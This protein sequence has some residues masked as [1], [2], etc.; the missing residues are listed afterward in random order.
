MRKT[1]KQKKKKTSA[2]DYRVCEKCGHHCSANTQECSCGSQRF[3][4]SFVKELRRVNRALSVQIK[5]AHPAAENKDSVIS[6]YKW[7]PGGNANFNILTPGQWEAIRSIIDNEL[8]PILGWIPSST[9]SKKMKQTIGTED[10]AELSKQ[11]PE[12]FAKLISALKIH[13]E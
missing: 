9:A 12:K 5:D 11:H 13:I 4:P 8:G 3:A 10:L 2:A 7:W 6:L 1:K